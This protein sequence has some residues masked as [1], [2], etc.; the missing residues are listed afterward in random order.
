MLTPTLSPDI[1]RNSFL[2]RDADTNLLQSILPQCEYQELLAG[3]TLFEQDSEPD[4]MYFLQDGQ[5]HVVRHYPDGSEVVLATEIPYYVIGELSLLA[6]KPRTGSVVAVGNCDLVRM[7][8]DTVFE[9][10]HQMPKVA[11]N[12]L[13]HLGKRLYR[14]NL[15]VRES[16]ISN[17]SGR[18][19]T[20]LVM[21]ADN[22]AGTIDKPINLSRLARA[23]AIDTDFV[24]HLIK[25]WESE[26][27]LSLDEKQ[28]TIFDIEYLRRIAG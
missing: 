1:L 18:V 5:I 7:S 16:A 27:V 4:A 21:M 25:K 13:T 3:E 22:K 15:R 23:T 9:V 20:L 28:I 10:F 26:A 6:N 2:F 14:L 17:V 8:R 24:K 19:A 11:V 12:A